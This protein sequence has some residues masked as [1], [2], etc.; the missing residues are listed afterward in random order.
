MSEGSNNE[1]WRKNYIEWSLLNVS[2]Y[3]VNQTQGILFSLSETVQSHSAIFSDMLL[4]SVAG[5]LT[6]SVL[7][8][9][10]CKNLKKETVKVN[11][12]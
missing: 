2:D 6:V 1:S 5:L 8:F 9:V 4:G 11:E 12:Q 3:V 7:M 10:I